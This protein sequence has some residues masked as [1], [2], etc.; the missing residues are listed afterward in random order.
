MLLLFAF[1]GNKSGGASFGAEVWSGK[2]REG[3]NSL[4]FDDIEIPVAVAVDCD[5]NWVVA[6]VLE[7]ESKRESNETDEIRS[8]ESTEI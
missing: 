7:L 8:G 3:T 4:L 6:V 2:N 1:D 5:D